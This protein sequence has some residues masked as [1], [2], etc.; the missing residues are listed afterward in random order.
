M[1]SKKRNSNSRKNRS[2]SKHDKINSK[3][4]KNSSKNKLLI[5]SLSFLIL[6]GTGYIF[7]ER[8]PFVNSIYHSLFSR[9]YYVFGSSFDSYQKQDPFI[10]KI[11]VLEK[12]IFSNERI[13][14]LKE[15]SEYEIEE[16]PFYIVYLSISDSKSKATVIKGVGEKLEKAWENAINNSID[17]KNKNGIEPVWIKADI[18]DDVEKTDI[19]DLNEILEPYYEHF[20]R[21][22]ISFDEKFE[23]SL[24]ESEINANKIIN[25]DDDVINHKKLNEYLEEYKSISIEEIPDYIYQFSTIGYFLDENNRIYEL[26]TDELNYGRRKVTNVDKNLVE[27][28]I[29][30]SAQF[31]INNINEDGKFVYG[32]FPTYD[33]EIDNYN[34]LRHTGTIWSLVIQYKLTGDESIIPKI[35]RGIEYLIKDAVVYKDDNTAYIVERKSNEI[36]AGGNGVAIIMLTSYMEEFKTD[37]Y[38]DLVIKLGNGIL[39]LQNNE[40]GYYHVLNYPDFT[41]KEEYRTVYYDG[42]CTFAL[43]K[44]YGIS[45]DPKWLNAASLSVDYFIENDYTKYRDHWVAY[46]VNEVTKYLPEE[47]YFEFG[48]KNAELNLERIY[49]QKTSYHTYLE[50]LMATFELYDRIIENDI[51]VAYIANFDIHNL[52]KTI[53]HRASH[54]LNGYFYPEYAMYFENP[55]RILNSFFIRH[56]IFRIRID[57]VQH[58]IGGY[59]NYYVYFDKINSY[60]AN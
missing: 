53:N 45:K 59:Y 54:M 29:K 22:G 36:K 40:G 50:L 55:Q 19:A 35:D 28:I 11:M 41:N 6:I 12:E 43:A 56:D 46:S 60:G 51:K 38:K 4:R 20:Y 44:I 49:N 42:E 21:K 57:D 25:Y 32:Y 30:K 31:L 14:S 13:K 48:L 9:D 58:F 39:E 16:K 7:R 24:I 23:L 8:I 15:G 33:K 18:V 27:G 10:E 3:T 52:V 5:L 26:Y 17:Y 34:I 47:R 2:N 37:K 1:K